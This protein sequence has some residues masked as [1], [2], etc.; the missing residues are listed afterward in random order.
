[1]IN[2]LKFRAG[3]AQ[4]GHGIGKPRSNN[5]FSFSPIDYGSTKIVNIG[6]SLVDPEI[7][8]EVTTSYEGGFDIVMLDRRISAEFTIYKKIHDNQQGINPNITRCWIQW[9]ANQC[10]N[11]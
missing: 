9:N 7:K 6:G 3:V 11:S 8:P 5:T 2:L 10:R 1:M 4:V